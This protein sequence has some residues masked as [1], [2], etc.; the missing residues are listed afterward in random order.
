[1]FASLA[2]RRRRHYQTKWN[3][4]ILLVIVDDRK[5]KD[6]KVEGYSFHR[7]VTSNSCYHVM[8]MNANFKSIISDD[9]R[10]GKNI[11]ED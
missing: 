1:M 2:F 9:F 8:L 5:L 3:N 11:R 7:V 4:V 6:I 10:F